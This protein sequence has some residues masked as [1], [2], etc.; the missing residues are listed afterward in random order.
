M[1][2]EI[3]HPHLARCLDGDLDLAVLDSVEALLTE[4][5][6]LE[7]RSLPS[8]L[9]AASEG[10]GLNPASGY[11]ATWLRDTVHIA[12]ALWRTGETPRALAALRRLLDFQHK[13]AHRF[14]DVLSGKADPSDPNE[15]PHVRFDGESLEEIDMIWAHAQNDALGA[16]L[17]LAASM[18]REGAFAPT[19]ADLSLLALEVSYL[20]ALPYHSDGDSGHWEEERR[21]NASSIGVVCAAL[22]ELAAALEAAGLDT[23]GETWTPS[24]LRGLYEPG[25]WWLDSVLPDESPPQRGADAALVF[26]VEPFRL[27]DDAQSKAVV[28]RVRDELEGP[29]GIRRYTGDSYW[30]ADYRKLVAAE[31]RSADF[32]DSTAERDRLLKPG[33]EAQW[34]LADPLLAVWHGRRWREKRDPEDRTHFERHLRRSLG[35]ITGPGEWCAEGLCPEAWFVESSVEGSYR[36]N[37]QTPLAWTQANLRLALA[38]ARRVLST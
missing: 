8:G 25:E 7:I 35:Q 38:E 3:H 10:G 34:C 31:L 12:H 11:Q 6:T 5:G 20:G 4:W 27:L 29:Y 24:Q 14:E 1:T 23:L 9:F 21:V 2:V 28:D 26:L 18:W 22:R 19:T 15:R 17:W 30:C 13:T 16:V 32:S 33:T 36:P 37:D